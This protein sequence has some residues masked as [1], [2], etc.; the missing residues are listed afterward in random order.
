MSKVIRI[1]YFD[2]DNRTEQQIQHLVTSF[3][4]YKEDLHLTPIS[5][6]LLSSVDFLLLFSDHELLS[7]SPESEY[8][9]P[10]IVLEVA[11]DHSFFSIANFDQL[12]YV[13]EAI[14]Q[15]QYHIENRTMLEIIIDQ[16]PLLALNDIY[17]SSTVPNSRIRYD[18]IIDGVSVSD[19]PDSANALLIS[20]PTG[21]TAMAMNLGGSLIYPDAA[22]F[23]I[24]AIASRNYVRKQQIIS[25]DSTVE[26]EILDASFP[27]LI[28]MDTRRV[29]LQQEI[30]QISKA[31]T[32]F[33]FV[34]LDDPT[35]S[36]SLD[37]KLQ[38]KLSFEDTADLT[39]SAKFILHVLQQEDRGLTVN[40]IGEI[41]HLQNRKTLRN[42]LKLLIEKGFVRR[43]ENLE[44]L[45]EFLYFFN[46]PDLS[47]FYN[48]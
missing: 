1:G 6:N 30:F 42:A 19:I 32:K 38:Y 20:T 41:T 8:L 25:D 9:P 45:R 26:I 40:D 36:P 47:K 10:V 2:A 29:E 5:D 18:L 15:K 37:R 33:N 43:Q 44:D 21:S 34:Q 31:R 23:Q 22:V 4:A 28:Q 11:G 35:S 46:K 24:Q 27:L 13:L 48:T 12:G 3:A 7:I 17:L 39:S 14:S 16:T